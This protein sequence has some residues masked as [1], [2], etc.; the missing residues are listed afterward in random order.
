MKIFP[1]TVRKIYIFYQPWL[2]KICLFVELLFIVIV[3]FYSHFAEIPYNFNVI[4]YKYYIYYISY[5]SIMAII[6]CLCMYYANLYDEKII[7]KRKN[8]L[9][10]L[11]ISFIMSISIIEISLYFINFLLIDHVILMVNFGIIFCCI[12]GWRIS[13]QWV[14]TIR[15]LRTR[16]LIVGTG[17]EARM[18]AKEL[19]ARRSLGYDV[20]G[21]IDDNPEK[22][23][24][25]IINPRVIG[26]YVQLLEVVGREKIDKI[27]VALP[28]R[29][30]K[31]PLEALIAC[32]LQGVEIEEGASFFEQISGRVLL[33]HLRPS[34]MIFSRGLSG[35]PWTDLY[36]RLFDI[37]GSIIGIM[38]TLPLVTIVAGLIKCD[39][40][41]PIFF[42]QQRV[43][44]NGK[45]FNLIKFRSMRVD[46]EAATGPVYA[47]ENDPRVTRVGKMLRTT[48]LDELPQLLN[49]IRGEMSFIGPRPERPF[50]VKQFEKEIPYYSH[51]LS[52]KPGI[53]GWAQVNYPYGSNTED[54][55]KKLE[56]DLYYIKHLSLLLE[57][58]IILKTLKIIFL[59]T[60][61]R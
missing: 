29:R 37:G 42:T 24:V 49:V 4:D 47:C 26:N 32:K 21:F 25:S 19:L 30:G 35:S 36:K 39:S 5:I 8:L 12:S 51:R 27:I 1:K 2:L 16:I 11:V 50:F 15:Q 22:M 61:A 38:L 41:G 43:G 57:L 59:G 55:V 56:Y 10:N 45:L 54:A 18:V 7:I 40:Q 52:V 13:L 33:E 60:G 31:L 14:L 28:D 53:T 3:S 34:W 17:N 44:Q 46:A 9:I 6:F 20:T 23:G 58:S 48:R